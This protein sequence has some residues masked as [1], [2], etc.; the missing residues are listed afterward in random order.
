MKSET[1][2]FNL[3]LPTSEVINKDK[4]FNFKFFS[5]MVLGS[6]HSYN[7][8]HRYISDRK[9]EQF[10]LYV[11]NCL[12]VEEQ[13]FTLN[14]KK[15][16]SS[17]LGIV[18]ATTTASGELIYQLF[19][20]DN[21]GKSYILV[22]NQTLQH[23]VENHMSVE[24]KVYLQLRILAFAKKN[25]VTRQDLCFKLGYNIN[26]TYVMSKALE[27]LAKTDVIT[28][29]IKREQIRTVNNDRSISTKYTTTSY[30]QIIKM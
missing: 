28:L 10:K 20:K 23:L 4:N 27:N 19:N 2:N 6:N 16:C 15:L 29:D 8:D 21:N 17:K 1:I 24:I 12:G 3:A 7:E 11:L 14:L 30:F 25:Y 18:R 9:L 26:S 5:L 22:N 13:S